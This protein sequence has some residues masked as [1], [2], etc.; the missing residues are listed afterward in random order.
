MML[1]GPY[2]PG[3]LVAGYFIGFLIYVWRSLAVVGSTGIMMSG[4]RL[5]LMLFLWTIFTT[6]IIAATIIVSGMLVSA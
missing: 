5:F 1:A 3:I 6:T 4:L 2:L